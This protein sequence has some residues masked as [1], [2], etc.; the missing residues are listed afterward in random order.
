MV[1]KINKKECELNFGIGFIRELDEKYFVVSKAGVK[2]GSGLETKVPM[3]LG[4]DMVT[5]SEFIYMGTSRMEKE[6]P[7]LREVDDYIDST[8]DIEE[9][10]KQVVDELKKSNACKIK[11]RQM[12]ENMKEAEEEMKR[13]QAQKKLTNG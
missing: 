7:S 3:L 11:V 10:L 5:L 6:R 1:L 2:F 9:L 4:G 12:E 8:E 13:Q